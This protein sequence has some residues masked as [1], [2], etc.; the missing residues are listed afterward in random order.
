MRAYNV[1]SEA[2]SEWSEELELGTV[3]D[4][5]SKSKLRKE[6]SGIMRRANF[7]N[8]VLAHKKSRLATLAE[9]SAATASVSDGGLATVLHGSVTSGIGEVSSEANESPPNP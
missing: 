2:P 5:A 1:G 7:I 8:G 9:G 4:E 3:M 6:V